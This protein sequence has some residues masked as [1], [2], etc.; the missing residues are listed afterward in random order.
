MNSIYFYFCT[1]VLWDIYN[2]ADVNNVSSRIE[3]DV[4]V[5]S[6]GLDKNS[7][8]LLKNGVDLFSNFFY[9]FFL[10]SNAIKKKTGPLQPG[11]TI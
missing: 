5:L 3:H 6:I 2:A 4:E 1:S 9:I 7:R 8:N 11:I 10:V